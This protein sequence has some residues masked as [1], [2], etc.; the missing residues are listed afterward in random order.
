MK[1]L[2]GK[3][4]VVTAA[5]AGIGLGIAERLGAEG[6]RLFISSRKAAN[7]EETLTALRAKDIAA[8]GCACHV[9]SSEQVRAM[10]AKAVEAYGKIDVL[11]SNAAVNPVATSI[12]DTP[13]DAITKI[14]DINVKSAIVLVQAARK[15]MSRGGSIVF[16][17]SVT[18]YSPPLPIGV[19]AV[20]K[21]A[22]LGLTKGLAA[23]LG[24]EVSAESKG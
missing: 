5:T 15:H 24:P 14:F 10:V 6:A 2:E 11:I 8:Q 13:E 23:E 18:A 9:G 12:V 17:S 20:S 22:L 16:V 4:A 19:Y 21:T 1:R 3:V 7:V